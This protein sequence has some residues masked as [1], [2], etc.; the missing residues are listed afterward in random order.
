MGFITQY[1]GAYFTVKYFS[2]ILSLSAGR[3]PAETLACKS[4]V[5]LVVEC[6]PDGGINIDQLPGSN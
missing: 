1:E 4:M 6:R 2:S 5:L 3:V